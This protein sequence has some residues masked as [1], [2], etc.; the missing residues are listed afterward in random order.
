MIINVK[1]AIGKFKLIKDFKTLKEYLDYELEQL[2]A[3]G[4]VIEEHK[5]YM[6]EFN[7][8]KCGEM[9]I[10]ESMEV[11]KDNYTHY[12]DYSGEYKLTSSVPFTMATDI[13]DGIN[14]DEWKRYVRDLYSFVIIEGHKKQFLKEI[15]S[16]L[17]AFG[18]DC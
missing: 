5:K 7:E 9:L 17:K 12:T 4:I 10:P 11:L 16:K 14:I 13:D 1:T 18:E 3:T 6:I 8:E 15:G 2:V